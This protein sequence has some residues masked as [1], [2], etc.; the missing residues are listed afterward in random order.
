MRRL[1]RL[2]T[3]LLA[4]ALPVAAAGCTNTTTSS[5]TSTTSTSASTMITEAF[6]GS[7]LKNG[8]ATFNFAATTAGSVTAQIKSMSPDSTALVGL[9]LGTWNGVTCSVV[10]A[11]DAASVGLTISGASSAAGN[12]CV[13]VYDIGKLTTTQTLEVT[14]THF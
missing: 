1:P 9:A 14:I 4:L 6:S 12:L 13:R 11:N 2:T 7:I 8:A 3:A 5:T 10:I